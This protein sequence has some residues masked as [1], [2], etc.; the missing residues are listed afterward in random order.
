MLIQCPVY[1]AQPVHGLDISQ[2]ICI[3]YNAHDVVLHVVE[4]R[5]SGKVAC[6]LII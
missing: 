4:Y 6:L 5:M 1:E 2:H 3:K